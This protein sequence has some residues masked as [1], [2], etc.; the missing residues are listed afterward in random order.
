M[1]VRD[2]NAS[3]LANETPWDSGLVARELRILTTR[4][5]GKGQ[6]A[7]E[8]GC[9]SGTN[10]L[11]LASCGFDVTGV[12]IASEAIARAQLQ[13]ASLGLSAR[14][15]QQDLTQWQCHEGAYDLL[16]DRGC[17]HCLRREGQVHRYLSLAA[18]AVKQGGAALV[19]TG[20][21]DSHNT[22]GP[23]KLSA[24]DL[25]R[26]WEGSFE[27]LELSSTFFEDARHT[28]GPL[29]WSCFMRRRNR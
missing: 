23:P 12:D 7:L 9:G 26:D 27:I 3:Y 6:K 11:Y 17:Y 18:A 29:G 22:S 10:A 20:N 2:W 21:C 28:P 4:L 25:V 19:L 14:F 24:S 15:L 13:A 16:F 5:R 1:S 8:L